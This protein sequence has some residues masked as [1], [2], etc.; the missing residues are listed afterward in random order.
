MIME[1]PAML[2]RGLCDVRRSILE[3]GW[4]V[5]MDGVGTTVY[6]ITRL[7]LRLKG[8]SEII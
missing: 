1:T 3:L 5:F 2:V 4:V 8:T 7:F 6:T